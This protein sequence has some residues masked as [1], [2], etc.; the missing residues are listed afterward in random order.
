LAERL[1]I[2]H[3]VRS[4]D[5]HDDAGDIP[6]VDRRFEERANRRAA[7]RVE[8]RRRR[9]PYVDDGE[10]ERNDDK[11]ALH[12]ILRLRSN[13]ACQLPTPKIQ[14]PNSFVFGGWELEVG[15]LRSYASFC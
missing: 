13:L 7:L 3:A 6:P 10:Q 15:F 5:E 11:C 8:R 1:V 4:G 9:G 12:K 2:K 14:P